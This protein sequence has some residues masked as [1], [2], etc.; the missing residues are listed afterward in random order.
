MLLN[1]SVPTSECDEMSSFFS[2]SESFV[3]FSLPRG[4]RFDSPLH[5]SVVS[6]ALKISLGGGWVR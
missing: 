6:R 3:S 2:Q 5:N 1:E 4:L